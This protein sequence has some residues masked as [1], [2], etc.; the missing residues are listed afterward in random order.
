MFWYETEK[1]RLVARALLAAAAASH[2]D[3]ALLAYKTV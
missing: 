2:Y 1:W 3:C